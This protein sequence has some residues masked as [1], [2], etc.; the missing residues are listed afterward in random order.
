MILCV[1]VPCYIKNKGGFNIEDMILITPD[2][3]EK[4]TYRTPHYLK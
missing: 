3:C 2:G 1:E 4:L